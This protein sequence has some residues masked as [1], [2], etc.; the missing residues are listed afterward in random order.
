MIMRERLLGKAVGFL[1][2]FCLIAGTL[3]GSVRAQTSSEL[4]LRLSSETLEVYERGEIIVEPV[5]AA[6]NP[7]D[8]DSIALDLEVTTPSGR[9]LR[10]PG[11]YCRSFSR[12]LEGS[13]EV[14]ESQEEGSWRLRWL[15]TEV[16]RHALTATVTRDGK[17]VSR[18]QATVNVTAGKR[19]GLARV[20]PQGKRYFRLDDGTPLFLNGLCVC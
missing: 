10:I 4:T 9:T 5:T 3:A 8:P 18:G 6:E 19:Q 7:F 14:L 15:A 20:E 16:G 17:V 12:K 13:R 1:V 11:F 2:G